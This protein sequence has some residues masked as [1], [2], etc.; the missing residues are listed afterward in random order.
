MI[1]V[2]LVLIKP[3]ATS[4]KTQF[5][6]WP[7]VRYLQANR[8]IVA[9]GLLA[10]VTE[11]L[12]TWPY[13]VT[14]NVT[15]PKRRTSQH[16]VVSSQVSAKIQYCTVFHILFSPMPLVHLFMVYAH[17]HTRSIQLESSGSLGPLSYWTVNPANFGTSSAKPW[18][19]Y[20]FELYSFCSFRF[21][22]SSTLQ[23]LDWLVYQQMPKCQKML[24][25]FVLYESKYLWVLNFQGMKKQ[26]F[27][28]NIRNHG[29]NSYLV[30]KIL[31]E[32]ITTSIDRTR[33]CHKGFF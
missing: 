21:D 7:V 9:R 4:H 15:F 2:N 1:R 23:W 22:W 17:T 12:F 28:L 30:M 32:A 5:P 29:D 20:L 3:V 18:C 6:S 8:N 19:C 10:C 11:A 16:H 13:I 31:L 14:V 26:V 27:D 25:S 24:I 33:T